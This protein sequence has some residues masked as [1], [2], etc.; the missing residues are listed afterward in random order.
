MFQIYADR[1]AANEGWTLPFGR[2]EQAP[3][4]NVSS[5]SVLNGVGLSEGKLF[6]PV[7]DDPDA[8]L[9]DASRVVALLNI[10]Y[11]PLSGV[12]SQS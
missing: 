2:A 12:V 8:V 5:S 6:V 10:G 7:R 1:S 3:R 4:P 11:V 9:R